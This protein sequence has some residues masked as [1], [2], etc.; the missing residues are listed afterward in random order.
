MSSYG[1]LI[2][3]DHIHNADCM[4][5]GP[6]DIDPDTEALLLRCEG[7]PFRIYNADSRLCYSG[8]MV[9]PG[10]T[11]ADDLLHRAAPLDEYGTPAAGATEIRYD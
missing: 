1:W 10:C 11:E 9:E 3:R 4:V 6:P 7:L 8:L 5:V 2:H